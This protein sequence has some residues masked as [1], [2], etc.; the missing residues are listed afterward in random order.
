MKLG[1]PYL[2]SPLDD[3]WSFFW[4]ALWATLF[5]H[6]HRGQTRREVAWRNQLCSEWMSREDVVHA[7]NNDITI[8]NREECSS[9][10]WAMAPLFRQ[11]HLFL[12]EMQRRWGQDMFNMKKEKKGSTDYV[13]LFNKYAYSGVLQIVHILSESPMLRQKSS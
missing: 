12:S 11:W 8:E 7:I 6:H 2:Q 5:N 9:I 3:L 1:E 4:T 10:L 13:M